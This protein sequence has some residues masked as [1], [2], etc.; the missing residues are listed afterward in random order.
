M[1]LKRT[2]LRRA[3]SKHGICS[4]TQADVL[5]RSGVVFVNDLLMKDPLSWVD[6]DQDRIRI[7]SGSAQQEKMLAPKH[8]YLLL[9][10]PRGYVTS[11]DDERGRRCVYDLLP[12]EY[13]DEWVF[14]VGRLDR[15]SEGL[16]LF[17]NDGDFGNRLTDPAFHVPKTYRVLLNMAL[18][19][20]DR[21]RMENG[22][23][24]DGEMT[25]SARVESERGLWYRMT[26][27][28]G[29]NRQIRKMFRLIKRRV[30]RLIRI[31]IG[32]IEVDGLEPGEWRLLD[33]NIIQILL[34]APA[35]SHISHHDP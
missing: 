31:T 13:Q 34:A 24:I 29:R 35:G 27:T 30:R 1:T 11:R 12:P 21:L 28:E 33:E 6:L 2:Q 5:I 8:I 19:E 15:D 25:R 4:R 22:M 3:L 7:Y 26:L 17:T 10:K 16:L 32:P 14:P 20:S 18:S 9:F 23:L